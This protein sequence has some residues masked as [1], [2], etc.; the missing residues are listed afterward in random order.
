[1]ADSNR[2]VREQ[3]MAQREENEGGESEWKDSRKET[4]SSS[5]SVRR[6]QMSSPSSPRPRGAS[7]SRVEWPLF[8]SPAIS[9][10]QV[11][12][13]EINNDYVVS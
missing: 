6:R 3:T 12:G 1:M 11:T 10:M 2:P 13:F 9:R 7:I 4:I 5:Q 8:E